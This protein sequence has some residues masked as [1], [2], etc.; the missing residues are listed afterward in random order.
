VRFEYVSI[1]TQVVEF[2]PELRPAAER[3]WADE[4]PP[5]EDSGPYALFG[6]VVT[7]FVEVLLAMPKGGG[8]DRLL[9]RAYELV[10]GM[11][12]QER[13]IDV[14]DLAYVEVLEWMGPW[15]Y[16]RSLPF[17][18]PRA[19]AELDRWEDDWRARSAQ[20][21]KADQEREIIDIYG[22]R[23]VVLAEL[24]DEGI[25]VGQIPGISAPRQWQR[26]PGIETARAVPDAVAFVSCYGTSQPYVLSPIAD[27]VC[28]EV[29]LERLAR[30]LADAES[31]EPNR[32]SKAQAG[33]YRIAE[34]ERVWG[35]A[36]GSGRKHSRWTGRLWIVEQF[37]A[38]GLEESIR[39]VL[40][41]HSMAVKP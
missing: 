17:L 31:G 24:T 7:P 29:A 34:G 25:T 13:D 37:A 6:S 32:G 27:V 12:G 11:L 39:N 41:G 21:A 2:L 20:P 35:M 26:L 28:E 3:Y 18:G 22:V 36:D 38:K 4:G 16:S 15:W 30:D 33:F 8:R 23:D 19:I 9:A 5:G 10:D 14:H 1:E 40:A